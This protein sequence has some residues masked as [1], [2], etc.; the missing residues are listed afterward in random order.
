MAA[1][2]HGGEALVT[3]ITP[4][5]TADAEHEGREPRIRT[6]VIFGAVMLLVIVGIIVLAAILG[7]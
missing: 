5:P 3:T 1:E 4:A 2:E 6:L 7:S